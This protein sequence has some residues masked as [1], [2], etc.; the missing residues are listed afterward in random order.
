MADD[1]VTL[2]AS[3][4]V[5]FLR[6][7]KGCT[8]DIVSES[9]AE[10][11][12]TDEGRLY[13][14][15]AYA[16]DFILW[17]KPDPRA[18]KRIGMDFGCL[19]ELDALDRELRGLVLDLALD[20]EDSLRNRINR[21]AMERIVDPYWLARS[22]LD[23]VRETVLADQLSRF[24]ADTAR[25]ATKNAAALLAGIDFSDPS[26]A[27]KAV[28]Q[29][30]ALLETLTAGRDPEYVA[31][32]IARMSSSTYSGGIVKRYEDRPITYMAL[33]ELVSFGPLVGFYKQ[34]FKKGGLLDCTDEQEVCRANKNMLRQAQSMRNAAAHGDAT[35]HTLADYRSSGT[36]KGV[37]RKL[38][39]F[40]I[41]GEWA[42]NV[43]SVPVAMELAAVLMCHYV[44]VESG[45]KRFAAAARLREAAARFGR[46]VGWFE[47]CYAATSF[48]EF[49]ARAFE[50]FAGRYEKA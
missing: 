32:S 21:G 20:I 5:E 4:Q 14:V 16:Q 47:K 6:E 29:V 42:D 37:R 8:F 11:I 7:E 46:N 31:K 39:E 10:R 3:E 33:L 38:G 41:D 28:N 45:E 27:T 35:L 26:E 9:D 2:T 36:L 19:L 25:A 43:A 48:I 15:K 17:R 30:L 13:R 1:K 18:G 44:F 22:Y 34:C 23:A 12:L 24:D 40:G 50:V 49:A